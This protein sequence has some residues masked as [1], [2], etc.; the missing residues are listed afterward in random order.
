MQSLKLSSKDR[1]FLQ[2]KAACLD[3]LIQRGKGKPP[4]LLLFLVPKS[5]ILSHFPTSAG[6]SNSKAGCSGPPSKVLYVPEC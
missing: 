1:H 6:G 3:F 5:H 2:S 4:L